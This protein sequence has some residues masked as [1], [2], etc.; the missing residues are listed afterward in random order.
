M[1]YMYKDGRGRSQV[2]NRCGH[3]CMELHVGRCPT[4]FTIWS[5]MMSEHQNALAFSREDLVHISRLL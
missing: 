1:Y 3:T 2:I 4:N 5:D